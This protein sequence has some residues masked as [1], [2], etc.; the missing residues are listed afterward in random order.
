MVIN[1]TT[2][3]TVRKGDRKGM[4]LWGRV[5][6]RKGH[7]HQNLKKVKDALEAECSGQREEQGQRS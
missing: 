1:A 7:C 5:S 3:N 2:K 4:G 6:L